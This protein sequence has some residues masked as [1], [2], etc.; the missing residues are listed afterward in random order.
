MTFNPRLARQVKS[1]RT[2]TTTV[3][4]PGNANASAASINLEGEHPAAVHIEEAAPVKQA[5]RFGGL[6]AAKAEESKVAPTVDISVPEKGR[7]DAVID[8][9]RTPAARQAKVSIAAAKAL[10]PLV[11][12]IS[13]HPGSRSELA[14]KSKALADL[15]T[16]VQAAATDV[17]I[18]IGPNV[19]SNDWARGQLMMAISS[20]AA[21]QWEKTG[22][23]NISDIGS[24]MG[25][26]FREPSP[27]LQSA[28]DGFEQGEKYVEANSSENYK[29]R[30]SVTVCSAFWDLHDWIT[31]K[32][33][34]LNAPD[35]TGTMPSRFF[36]YGL[37]ISDV[38]E[39]LMKRII[40][41]A[42][43]FELLISSSDL[44]LAHLQGTI[45]RLT[46]IAGAEYVTQTVAIHQWVN[47]SANDVEHQ[48]RMT[49]VKN[50]FESH[51]VPRVMEWARANFAA[52]ETRAIAML[53]GKTK[54]ITNAEA[55]KEKS[56]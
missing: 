33:L 18:A 20:V 13:F 35:S 26:A 29:A 1:G 8:H 30:L 56:K 34:Q 16:Q 32:S 6:I 27:E 15:V 41:E 37:P 31:H 45:R 22:A 3:T 23:A 42:R 19:A 7:F 55:A 4:N 44:K 51:L 5:S 10:T 52:I 24:C 12:A 50:Q 21:Q 49:Q 14:E 28:L 47:D 39:A 40:D 25:M 48:K 17:A 53:E 43:G 9:E 11:A 36:S 54:E 2:G 38:L 46:Q